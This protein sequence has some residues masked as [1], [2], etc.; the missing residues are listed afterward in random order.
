MIGQIKL[1]NIS[2]KRVLFFVLALSVVTMTKAQSPLFEETFD[3]GIPSTWTAMDIDGDGYRWTDAVSLLNNW[4]MIEVLEEYAVGGYGNAAVSISY[5][6]DD[7]DD[8]PLSPDNWL[9]SPAVTIPASGTYQLTW[10]STVSF[11][12]DNISVYVGNTND[13][14]AL[15]AATPV[16]VYSY[17]DEN[18][19]YGLVQHSVSLAAYAGQT[20]YIAFRHHNSYDGYIVS[21]DNVTVEPVELE[22]DIEITAVTTPASVIAGASATVSGVVKNNGSE[23]V[24]AFD[25]QYSFDGSMSELH[26]V[27]GLN[28]LY[29]ESCTF[30]HPVAITSIAEGQHTLVVTISNP[31]GAADNTGNNTYTTY[32]TACSPISDMAYV[33]T[34]DNGFGCWTAVDV[35]GDGQNWKLASEVFYEPAEYTY[36]GS[37]NCAVSQ[38]YDEEEWESYDPDNWLIS[39]AIVLPSDG[40]VSASWYARSADD[41][42]R[43]HYSVYV[44]TTNDIATLTATTP[45]YDDTPSGLQYQSRSV[46]LAAYSGQTVYIAF[47][48]WGSY[49]NYQLMIDQFS[50]NTISATPEIAL[51][52]MDAPMYAATNTAFEMGCTVTNNS[53][54]PITQFDVS[55]SVDGQTTTQHIS[56]CNIACLQPYTF[57]VNV[58]AVVAAGSKALTVTVSNPNG[59]TDNG[60]DNS[61]VAN[62]VFYNATNLPRRT[63]LM[64]TFVSSEEYECAG[65]NTLMDGALATGYAEDTYREHVVWVNHNIGDYEDGLTQEFEYEIAVL[66]DTDDVYVPGV[67]LDRTYWGNQMFTNNAPGAVFQ[68]LSAATWPM[69]LPWLWQSQR[70]CR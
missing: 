43:D 50:L 1:H 62:V 51:T 24:H 20:V 57:T 42:Y 17:D 55:C 5:Y 35:D 70:S 41:D 14:A 67:M 25:V 58:P 52:T 54:S 19:D 29:G 30:S 39:P 16:A 46:S 28:L 21:I 32:I 3:G 47:R 22:T 33:E 27:T 59:M 2:M 26:T 6:F 68:P 9:I 13:Y 12:E 4:D 69:P 8:I 56:G 65:I 10:Y 23:A 49:D 45:L 48:H 15:S 61:Q 44:A 63:V 37:L 66:Y 36:N 60:D 34:F 31:N 53:T 18:D 11:E 7:E 40:A 38:S 64:E